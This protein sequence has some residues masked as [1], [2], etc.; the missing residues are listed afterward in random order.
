VLA[1]GIYLRVLSSV[2]SWVMDEVPREIIVRGCEVDNVDGKYILLPQF[3]NGKPAYKLGNGM[4]SIFLFFDGAWFIGHFSCTEQTSI[5]HLM[6]RGLSDPCD[7]YPAIW[8]RTSTN[9]S[10]FQMRVYNAA[11]ERESQLSCVLEESATS[12][13]EQ[14]R[15][16]DEA[17]ESTV[18][19]DDVCLAVQRARVD[20][21]EATVASASGDDGPML[22]LKSKLKAICPIAFT[23]EIDEALNEPFVSMR[24]ILPN[25]RLVSMEL[26]CGT[27]DFQ[28]C[29]EVFVRE[30][31]KRLFSNR[32][33][34]STIVF[35]LG[36]YIADSA[37]YAL[38]SLIEA[39]SNHYRYK[40]VIFEC[41]R[42]NAQRAR[43]N[44]RNNQTWY[45]ENMYVL[46]EKAA[47]CSSAETVTFN[48]SESKYNCYRNSCS[49]KTANKTKPVT[50]PATNIF[51]EIEK[52]CANSSY[53][54]VLMKVDVEGGEFELLDQL[55]KL[56]DVV[57]RTGAR[58]FRLV[59]E[60]SL[61]LDDC[62]ENWRAR[63]K[64]AGSVFD[65]VWT[66][67][68]FE[69]GQLTFL[70]DPGDLGIEMTSL[71]GVVTRVTLGGQ[72]H[73][74]GVKPGWQLVGIDGA[75]FSHTAFKSLEAGSR[76]YNITVQRDKRFI[77]F[78]SGNADIWGLSITW[79]L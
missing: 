14:F 15:R 30:D 58:S 76:S 8:K 43:I 28:S 39:D 44:L 75:I 48:T 41:D 64:F 16:I 7:P 63:K 13:S 57:K 25:D 11:F 70:A 45:T 51:E 73:N 29:K 19:Q 40:V 62:L 67:R 21:N 34:G 54:H 74:Q 60:Y 22:K 18:T 66:K 36:G 5:M 26:R 71:S 46:C 10:C 72:A 68:K 65:E 49:H 78:G 53:E 33:K 61:D 24:Y 35:D 12:S 37:L 50:V 59:L 31:Y 20:V 23:Y 4:N 52:H 79:A 2:R 27:S 77:S 17:R 3:S 9:R 42:E 1:H 32:P 38:A 69:D 55:G 47:V 6:D 56:V